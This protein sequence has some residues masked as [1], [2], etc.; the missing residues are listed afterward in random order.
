MEVLT[1][2][3]I[4]KLETGLRKYLKADE[5]RVLAQ[6]F[7]VTTDF[8]LTGESAEPSASEQDLL[9]FRAK[10]RASHPG[11]EP[12]D[13][14]SGLTEVRRAEL[15]VLLTW[16]VHG[17]GPHVMLVQGPP[18]IGKSVLAMQLVREAE[19]TAI[20]WATRLLD[21]RALEP[22]ARVDVDVL[23]SRLFG[24][25]PPV[26]GDADQAS[27]TD[28]SASVRI[29]QRISRAGKPV[30]CVLDSAEELT[31]QTSARLRAALDEIRGKVR[32][33]GNPKARIA[34]VVASRLDSGWLGVR[35][36]P[37]FDV[38]PLPGFDVDTIQDKVRE[39]AGPVRRSEYSPGRF[40]EIA[41]TVYAVTAGIPRLLEP[42]LSWI[43]GQEWVGFERLADA[44]VFPA[45]TGPY[46][47]DTLLAAQSLFPRA[48]QVPAERLDVVRTAISF[49]VRYRFFTLTHLRHHLDTDRAFEESLKQADWKPEDLWIALSGLA[50]LQKPL[51]KVW[52]AF[53]PAIR[54]LLF[55][56]FYPSPQA[57]ELAHQEAGMRVATWAS[58]QRG[59]QQVDGRVEELWHA[60][61]ALRL[62]KAANSNDRLLAVARE[63]GTK[64]DVSEDYLL[65]D[66]SVYAAETIARDAELQAEIGDTA[67]AVALDN[68]VRAWGSARRGHGSCSSGREPREWPHPG[69]HS[70]GRGRADSRR[71]RARS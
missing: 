62:E 54:S 4:S 58:S 55:R 26:Q 7:G 11:Q 34:F 19:H 18:G 42:C 13:V 16:L 25:E 1:R 29:A 51:N 43:D 66:L 15:D 63:A 5:A 44:A 38:L 41:S 37:R 70:E 35:P 39:A 36:A 57:R 17:H 24:L 14:G 47:L 22:E 67:L 28:V 33:T 3:A 9:H 56:H 50:L 10:R 30:L 65:G 53:H 40:A 69:L 31:E 49:L 60:A 12:G 21:A 64:L 71:G 68:T 2:Q 23:V 27:A 45:L 48:V 6:I 32:E 61:S 20:G 52:Q 46:I 8:L 59:T